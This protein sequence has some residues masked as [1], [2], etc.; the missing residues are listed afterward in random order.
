MYILYY[1]I[2][3]YTYKYIHTYIERVIF[4]NTKIKFSFEISSLESSTVTH[5]FKPALGRLRQA[6]QVEGQ[7]GLNGEF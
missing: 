5:A 6:P 7:L 1:I 4:G 2:H 3:T